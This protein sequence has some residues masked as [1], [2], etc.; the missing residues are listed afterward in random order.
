MQLKLGFILSIADAIR[1]FLLAAIWGGSFLLMR[2]AAPVLGP[3]FLMEGRVFF[4]ASFLLGLAFVL[5]KKHAILKHWKRFFIMGLFNCAL[6]WY[7]FG[8][9]AIKLTTA[10]LSI[11]N[12]LAP[13]FAFVIGLA[14]RTE[15]LEAKRALGLLLGVVGVAVLFGKVDGSE[16]SADIAS[17]VMAVG[18][19]VAYGIATTYTKVI[20]GL[21]PFHNALGSLWMAS[22]ILLPTLFFVPVRGEVTPLVVMA[23]VAIGVV[24]SG[25]AFLIYF[26]LIENVGAS[27]ALTVSF[28]I[29][30]FSLL[31]G[32]VFLHEVVTLR[33]LVG[34]LIILVG[35]ALVTGFNVKGI[36]QTKSWAR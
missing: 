4:A 3:A 5:K 19:S 21:E 25:I 10:Q 6:P 29:P 24:C 12:A 16:G 36:F 18:A 26:K 22:L 34:M 14:M 2:I 17:I 33:T 23:T 30:V 11:I 1:L 35:T 27:S 32:V 31:F 28:L 13:L 7:L 15:R 9:A 20:K 8:Q